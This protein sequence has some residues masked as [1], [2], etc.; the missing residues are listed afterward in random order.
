MAC[1]LGV[2][3]A[4]YQRFA[5]LAA[6][7]GYEVLLFSYRGSEGDDPAVASYRLADWGR[8]DIDA[9]LAWCRGAR[10]SYRAISSATASARSCSVW[11]VRPAD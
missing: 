2:R 8:E 4:F 1:A 7:S 6:A 5:V 10:R 11:L 3:R 9:A